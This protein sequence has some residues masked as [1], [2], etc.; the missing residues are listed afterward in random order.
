MFVQKFATKAELNSKDI[1]FIYDAKTIDAHLTFEQIAKEID[2]K[3]GKMNILVYNNNSNINQETIEIS[4]DIIC[5]LVMKI[6]LL[7]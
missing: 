4:K 7:N 2:N 5:L 3:S 6:L 1:Y